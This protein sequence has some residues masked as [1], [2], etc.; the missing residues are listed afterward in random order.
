MNHFYRSAYK[1]NP[2]VALAAALE[3]VSSQD[4][5]ANGVQAAQQGAQAAVVGSDADSPAWAVV[6]SY[7]T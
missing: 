5:V 4:T 1:P 3:S 7:D 6:P 2:E